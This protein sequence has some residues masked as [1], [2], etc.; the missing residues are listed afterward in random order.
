MYPAGAGQ[1][2]SVQGLGGAIAG[3][4][5]SNDDKMRQTYYSDGLNAKLNGYL[6]LIKP[7]D[8]SAAYGTYKTAFDANNP[9][10]KENA[11]FYADQA[12]GILGDNAS[13]ADTYER[14]RS[15]NLSSLGDVFKSVL[16]H[17][18]ASQK[19][20][21]AA[22]GYG[23]SGP[24]SYDQILNSQMATANISPVLQSI[25]GNLGRDATASV[26]G[27]RA[28]NAY[29]MGQFAQDPL[30][31]YVDN[32]TAGR[33]FQPLMDYR[34][35]I[36]GDIGTLGNLGNVIKSNTSGY[37]LEPGLASRLNNVAAGAMNAGNFAMSMYGGA[38][39]GGAGGGLG[40][41]MGG[42]GGGG[43]TQP[44][45]ATM[46]ANGYPNSVGYQVPMGYS[47]PMGSY[48]GYGMSYGQPAM[49][50]VNYNSI[51]ATT[52]YGGYGMAY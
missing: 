36:N 39:G 28:W 18:L 48:N 17:G 23:G 4:D 12:K 24:S 14:L 42:M 34:T 44:D 27:D 9:L 40:S 29:R 11:A 52:P 38:M 19:A 26:G 15:G 45:G 32:A 5:S 3:L 7:K 8:L 47:Q 49:A 41:L 46:T 6:R 13:T 22:G 2:G 16:D 21:L 30:T 31:G 51:P 50:P 20:R 25:Y 33:V 37:Q 35:M 1:S 10:A 43:A